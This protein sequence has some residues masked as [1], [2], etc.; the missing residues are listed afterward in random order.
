MVNSCSFS[1]R[2]TPASLPASLFLGKCAQRH[3]ILGSSPLSEK[4]TESFSL[5]GLGHPPLPAKITQGQGSMLGDPPLS[6]ILAQRPC[7]RAHGTL[8]RFQNALAHKKRF[9]ASS[10]FVLHD[11]PSKLATRKIRVRATKSTPLL[12]HGFQDLSFLICIELANAPVVVL[13]SNVDFLVILFLEIERRQLR[14]PSDGVALTQLL[15][16]CGV[17]HV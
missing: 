3:N 9:Q 5:L 13:S 1:T 11:R 16:D 2:I 12:K 7:M 4:C 15:A 10:H 17:I 8:A 14:R 6:E